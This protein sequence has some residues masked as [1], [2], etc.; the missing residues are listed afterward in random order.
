MRV[1]SNRVVCDIKKVQWAHFGYINQ[2]DQIRGKKPEFS[3]HGVSRDPDEWAMT[4]A[5]EPAMTLKQMADAIK[6]TDIWT[7]RI[8]FV[9]ASNHTLVYTGTKAVSL[10]A[11]WNKRV[12]KEAMEDLKRDKSRKK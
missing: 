1:T 6:V 2:H 12:F 8:K 3:V 9:F 10:N 11:A 7:P 4:K 5:D